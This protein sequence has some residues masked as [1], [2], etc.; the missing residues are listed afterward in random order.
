M[1]VPADFAAVPAAA[2]APPQLQRDD[3]SSRLVIVALVALTIYSLGT[4]VY[5]ASRRFLWSDEIVTI[6][7][8]EQWR[9]R[10][11]WAALEDAADSNPP[12]FY[13]MEAAASRLSADP[14]LSY[15]LPSILAFLA[16][17][18]ALF[19]FVR[20]RAG[21]VP[22]LTAALV[23]FVTPL[24]RYYS[25]E[26]RPYALTSCCLACAM[27]LWQ[28]VDDR[29]PRA[30]ALGLLLAAAAAFHYYAVF[31]LAPFAAAEMW[32]SIRTRRARLQVW[33]AFAI[34]AAPL[35]AF[36][37]LLWRFKQAYGAHFW[38]Q[39]SLASVYND[40]L[41]LRDFWA[42]A[43]AGLLALAMLLAAA[44]ATAGV[45]TR[46]GPDVPAEDYA[47][48]AAFI[49][50][51]AI[52]FVGLHVTG[53]ALLSRYVMPTILGV[54]L[55]IGLAG[56]RLT[57]KRPNVLVLGLIAT[58]FGFQQLEMWRFGRAPAAK[59]RTHPD[60]ATVR[61][62]IHDQNRAGL[63]VVVS[64]GMT[65]ITMV[66]YEEDGGRSLPLVYLVDVD[67]AVKFANSDSVDRTV[68]S[69]RPYRQMRVEDAGDFLARNE[70][71]LLYS[72][73]DPVWDWQVQRLL[74][75]GASVQVS[76]FAGGRTLYLIERG[77]ARKS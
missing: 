31:A 76:A 26:A 77:A 8:A 70:R 14:H 37:P 40:L 44:R 17:P 25:I 35:I 74:A 21:S 45:A 42:V 19:L 10:G 66:H 73:N 2:Q 9:G 41:G 65:F 59:S 33:V 7:V 36:A 32:R 57:W 67:N 75:D 55:S 58:V 28:V 11:I 23:P 48:A 12:P 1:R 18:I 5:R 34:G 50:L 27:A 6:T 71:F 60:V 47:L 54:A 39:A 13:A 69:V 43:V 63:P 22:A 29:W 72:T 53:G 4:N 49:C 20:R 16:I 30:L 62:L 51:P 38:A 15:R 68:L 61:Q 3:L 56:A 64:N 24:F 52:V 46:E